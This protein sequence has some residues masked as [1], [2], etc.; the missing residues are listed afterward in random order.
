MRVLD[1]VGARPLSAVRASPHTVSS[2]SRMSREGTRKELEPGCLW[3]QT[4]G[5]SSGSSEPLPL[6]RGGRHTPTPHTR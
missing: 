3:G 6:R 5:G 1:P 2:G 4:A